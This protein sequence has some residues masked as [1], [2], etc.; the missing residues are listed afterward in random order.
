MGNNT[1]FAFANEGRDFGVPV[2]V[3][4]PPHFVM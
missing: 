2:N 3:F 4:L 1:S